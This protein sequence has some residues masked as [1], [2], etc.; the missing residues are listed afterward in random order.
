MTAARTSSRAQ[1][2]EMTGLKRL[3][4]SGA[5]NAQTWNSALSELQLRWLEAVSRAAAK[6]RRR[7]IVFAHHP[8]HPDGAHTLWNVPEVLDVLDRNRNIVAWFNGHNHAGACAVRNG[9]PF[10]TIEG[11]SRPATPTP[12]P[13]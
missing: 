2:C 7:V 4:D 5:A 3:T 1:P 11:M 6:E 13:S 9:V 8:V 10:V 12:T